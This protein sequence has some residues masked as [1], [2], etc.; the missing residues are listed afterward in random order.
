MP[1]QGVMSSPVVSHVSAPGTYG[2][3]SGTGRARPMPSLN[4]SLGQRLMPPQAWP[5]S[6][7]GVYEAQPPSFA[8]YS[9]AHPGHPARS[10]TGGISTH[11][12][13][14]GPHY[15]PHEA[16]L[17]PPPPPPQR[18]LDVRAWDGD[19]EKPKPR[20]TD[21]TTRPRRSNAYPRSTSSSPEHHG[22]ELDQ[23]C[24]H[25]E[26]DN[27][28]RHSHRSVRG[29]KLLPFTDSAKETWEVWYNRFSDV[30]SRCVWTMEEKLDH[31]LP[32]L[33]GVAGEFV[34]GQLDRNVQLDYRALIREQNHRFRRVETAKSYGAKFSSRHQNRPLT[35]RWN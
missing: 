11:H 32:K 9:G 7:P 28:S 25:S 13:P 12:M 6:H 15:P 24:D 29:P 22:D 26:G 23:W 1:H 16:S 34:Y 10:T 27:Q 8:P 17:P 19:Q 35:M 4:T 3:S 30:A 5:I 33:Q 18:P 31:L 21:V 14:W 2:L 20:G